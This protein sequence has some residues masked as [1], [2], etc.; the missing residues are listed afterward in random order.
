VVVAGAMRPA[1]AAEYDG[2]ANLLDAIRVAAAPDSRDRGVLV[3]LQGEIHGARDVTKADAQR[4]D[5]FRSTRGAVGSVGPGGPAYRRATSTRHTAWSEFDLSTVAALPR[6]DVVLVYQDA[7]G[8]IIRAAV[9]GGAR[10]IVIAAAGA[11][12]TSGTQAEAIR[13]AGRKGVL[14]VTATRTG[15]GRIERPPD[16]VRP[17]GR[18]QISAEDLH[19]LKARILLMLA[20]TTTGD[21]A[22]VQRMFTEY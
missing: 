9:D 12:A 21:A 8:D 22:R 4:L 10:G 15:S 5:A 18:H 13:Y 14:V 7:S 3:V 17:R 6:V 19:P 11:G 2:D 20:L 1:G 16:S